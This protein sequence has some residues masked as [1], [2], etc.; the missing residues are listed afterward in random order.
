M[1]ISIV[2][3]VVCVAQ[4]TA[5][6]VNLSSNPTNRLFNPPSTLSAT[7]ESARSKPKYGAGSPRQ[8]S[9]VVDAV[10][11]EDDAG[12][13]RRRE[14]LFSLLAS[15]VSATLIPSLPAYAEAAKEAL[16]VEEE[17]IA[18]AFKNAVGGKLIIPPMDT[19][20]YDTFTLPNGLKV[21]LCSDPG[22]NTA[23]AAMDVH[24]GAASD[25]DDVPGLAHL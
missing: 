14:L 18:N 16:I 24:V 17:S 5:F 4:I 12:S 25:P 20:S 19:R 7:G 13:Q 21:I 10:K 6:Q 23:S 9:V 3:L 8:R 2:T 22:S 1:R 15:S 11:S